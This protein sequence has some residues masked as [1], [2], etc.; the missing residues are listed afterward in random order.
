[1]E[2]PKHKVKKNA[3]KKKKK[4]AKHMPIVSP[5][6][7]E[8]AEVDL[9]RTGVSDDFDLFGGGLLRDEDEVLRSTAV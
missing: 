8:D 7:K 1:M 5:V 6:K 2:R 4:S 9:Y 3:K